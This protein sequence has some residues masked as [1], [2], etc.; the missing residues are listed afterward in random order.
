MN[1]L[2]SKFK[3]KKAGK[4]RNVEECNLETE[5]LKRKKMIEQVKQ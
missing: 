2:S 1:I 3:N 5:R 4:T